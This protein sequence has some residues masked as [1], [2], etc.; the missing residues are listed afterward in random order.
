LSW[1]PS[2]YWYRVPD[3]GKICIGGSP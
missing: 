2:C 3:P 1:P